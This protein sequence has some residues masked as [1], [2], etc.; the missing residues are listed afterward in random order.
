MERPVLSPPFR[1]PIAIAL[2][3]GLAAAAI[4]VASPLFPVDDAY[5]T[6]HNARALLGGGP[7]PV[8]GG[9]AVVGAT[10]LVHLALLAALGLVLPLPLANHLLI[11]IGVML[12][13]LGLARLA[14]KHQVNPWL[15]ATLG[16]ASAYL[17]FAL[18]NGLETSL[19][20]AMAVWLVLFIDRPALGW[21]AGLAP[22]VR[23][24]IGLLAAL[25]IGQQLWWLRA[26]PASAALL[27]GKALLVAIPFFLWS[28]LMSGTLFPSTGGAKIAFFAEIS[29]PPL[30]RLKLLL[31]TLAAS[32]LLLFITT[33]GLLR[34]RGGP[35]LL[36]WLALW[37]GLAAWTFPGGLAHNSYR[38]LAT[39]APVLVLGWISL[40]TTGLPHA[41]P[42]LIGLAVLS[43]AT[44]I[45][46]F[47][48]R[49]D[50]ARMTNRFPLLEADAAKSL[51]PG[52]RVL[53][54][55]AGFLAWT[56]PDLKL[57]D[58]V[59]LKSPQNIAWHQK[60]TISGRPEGRREALATIARKAR[61]DYLV[62]D[63]GDPFWRQT[64]EAL[65]QSGWQ[66]VQINAAPPPAN[67][68]PQRYYHIY[69][70]TPPP[71]PQ[72]AP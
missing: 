41:R 23:P 69:R 16:L 26:R 37:L 64:S 57:V 56:R 20:M 63:S 36:L 52:A 50:F 67:A 2:L 49:F 15:V 14:Q 66:V 58:I 28:W 9:T 12:Y 54:H 68:L 3:A 46:S 71:T 51:P 17:P 60:L 30:F 5:I 21:L 59:G 43:V 40:S 42:L 44:G 35:V 61:A 62:E 27:V 24:E 1:T 34:V 11:I 25:L 7:D 47:Q 33:P 8:Y 13:A 48:A 29:E 45:A 18:T 10:S 19:A 70:L 65:R 39:L 32:L 6:M 22:F 53:V 4:A 38:Y 72:R 55:D 31:N